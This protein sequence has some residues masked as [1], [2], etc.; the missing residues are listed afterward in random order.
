MK[1]PWSKNDSYKRY[2]IRKTDQDTV[3]RLC[4][5]WK[6]GINSMNKHEINWGKF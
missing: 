5:Q 3:F 1:T 6:D 2:E 4:R